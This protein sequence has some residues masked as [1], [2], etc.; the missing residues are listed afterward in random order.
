MRV[1]VNIDRLNSD[2]LIIKD[3]ALLRSCC[4]TAV[5]AMLGIYGMIEENILLNLRFLWKVSD[6]NNSP[7]RAKSG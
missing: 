5:S 6:R 7:K 4:F 3:V 2:L 1:L